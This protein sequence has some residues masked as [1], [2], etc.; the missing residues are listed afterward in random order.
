MQEHPMSL[1][2][3][4]PKFAINCSFV[5]AIS[6]LRFDQARISLKRVRTRV[7]RF[8]RFSAQVDDIVRPYP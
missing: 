3:T 5:P 4:R 1:M 7:S 8:D 6:A 2:I